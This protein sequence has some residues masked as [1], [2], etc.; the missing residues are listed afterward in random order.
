MWSEVPKP[1]RATFHLR[2][3]RALAKSD[4]R[5]GEIATH[6]SAAGN[7]RRAYAY[8]VRGADAASRVF[9]PKEEADLLALAIRHAP[10]ERARSALVG[11]L[12]KL[13]AHVRDYTRA[14]P[15]LSARLEHLT[16]CRVSAVE[17]LRAKRDLI[18]V[19]VYS[20][21][22]TVEESGKALAAFYWEVSTSGIEEPELEAE[23]LGAL[24]WAAARSFN[25]QL[26]EDT[27]SHIRRLHSR[28]R[29][30]DVRWRTARSLGIY[31]CYKGRLDRAEALL[32]EAL[33]S[34]T[35]AADEAAILECYIGR[36][37]LIVR[38]LSAN[39]AEEV[40]DS[41]LSL[42]KQHADPAKIAA[43]LCNCAVCLMHL[44][45]S[46]RAEELLR[47]ARETYEAAG[48]YP[49][50]SPSVLYNL[51]FVSDTKG[52]QESS[53]VYWKQA[54]RASEHDGVIPHRQ[55]CLAAL[56]RLALLRG[57]ERLA[58]SLAAQALR[59]ARRGDF[60]IDDR[61]IL[62]DLL[63]RLRMVAG[64]ESKALDQLALVAEATR[65]TD[66]RV[67]LRVQLTRLELLVQ[68]GCDNEAA[69]V[70]HDLREYADSKNA[71]W[72]NEQVALLREK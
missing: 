65:N 69:D 44:R 68:L 13:Y 5:Y 43:I 37:A 47:Q 24:L 19:E 39:Q 70:A 15:L 36:T 64:K 56:A 10:S 4:G 57:H 61:S 38:V 20:S 14:R 3:A 25:V 11:R 16:Q 31:E 1:L 30:P 42:A 2:A 48:A 22:C 59:L 55:E 71:S 53:E 27:I 21:T 7:A 34:A 33:D 23:I 17:I 41:A 72:W 26:V 28:I 67:H 62:E 66:A 51:G 52:D 45:D 18:L 8:A 49:D 63:A 29:R 35:D 32:Q 6:L 54:L 12:G 9:A 60:L 58:R 50:T 46:T 40:L